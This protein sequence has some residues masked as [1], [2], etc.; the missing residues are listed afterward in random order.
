MAKSRVLGALLCVGTILIAVL[1][2][3]FGYISAGA[4]WALSTLSFALP[5]TI[6]ILAVCV[7]GFWL[8]WIMATTKE[9]SPPPVTP[10]KEETAAEE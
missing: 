3:Y 10:K 7:L 4:P 5:I 8:G 9:V 6:G 1:H 2:I